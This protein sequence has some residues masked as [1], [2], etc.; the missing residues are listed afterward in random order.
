HAGV[1]NRA[2]AGDQLPA[3]LLVEPEPVTQRSGHEAG[4][5]QVSEADPRARPRGPSNRSKHF[6]GFLDAHQLADVREAESVDRTWPLAGE[7]PGRVFRDDPE[8]IESLP[9]RGEVLLSE[10]VG[11]ALAAE[12]SARKVLR[13]KIVRRDRSLAKSPRRPREEARRVRGGALIELKVIR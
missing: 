9:N 4:N 8:A 1:N 6:P 13:Q 12:V 7:L 2:V 5:H 10:V 11:N 3:Q